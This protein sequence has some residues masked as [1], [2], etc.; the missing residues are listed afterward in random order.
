[1]ERVQLFATCLGDLVLPDAVAR[2]RGA[3]ARGRVRGRLPGRSGLLRPAGVQLGPPRPPHAGSRARS[4]SAFS[5]DAPIVVP[6]GSCA[7]MVVAL[8]ARAAR[9]AS[10]STS[11]SSPRSSTRGALICRG[12]TRARI[13]YHDSCHML[14]E[15]RIHDAP[16]RLLER[17]GAELVA[18]RRGPISAAAS[19]ARSPSG[20]PSSRSRWPTTSSPA[21]RAPKR[22]SRPT[23]AASCTCADAPSSAE[24]GLPR[25]PPRDRAR[26]RGRRHDVARPPAGKLPRDRPAQ[27]RRRARVRRARRLDGTAHGRPRRQRGTRS[28][29]AEALRD[30]AHEARMRVI[31]DLDAHV[32]ALP[33]RRSRLAAGVTF[34]PR[35]PR[36]QTRTSS[37]SA[38]RAG[39]TLAAKSKS[40]AT[41]E[42]GL[43]EALEAA[44][45]R[46]VETDLGEYI[47][48]L[49]GEH[50][51]HII[52]PAIEKTKEDVAELLSARGRRPVR[53]R[54]RGA[55][56]GRA[57]PAP[58][59]VPRRR[60]RHHRRELRRLRHGL[61]RPRH[62]RGQRPPR[63]EPAA[64]STSR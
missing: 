14:R 20:S 40:M 52:A 37:T 54:A 32:D 56:A 60:R 49:A 38:A 24:V 63:V 46:R 15:L 41:E 11:G 50:P 8:P 10:R 51:V 58:R 35:R 6:S 3:A 4:R 12:E 43:N 33:R 13:A 21:P 27:A 29:D 36:T 57:A 34:S 64:R 45:V 26:T 31:D 1:M 25:R 62:E 28:A 44:G 18:A 42:I 16:R 9:R 30:R 47:L 39:A 61:G 5:R 19:A 17:S 53:S 59:D 55:D 7:T 23:R 48:Q 22:S 2:R